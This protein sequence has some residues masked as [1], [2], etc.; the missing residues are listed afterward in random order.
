MTS[1]DIANLALNE[2]ASSNLIDSLTEQSSTA[3]TV[4]AWYEPL[5]KALLRAAPWGCARTQRMLTQV[6]DS[7]AGTSPYPWSYKFAYPSDCVHLRYLLPTVPAGPVGPQ[8]DVGAPPPQWQSPS[9][10]NRFLTHVEP[11]VGAG[12][13]NKYIISN[14]PNAIAVFNLD[15]NNPDIWD[16]LFQLAMVAALASKLAMPVTGDTAIRDRMIQTAQNAINEARAA[17]ANEAIQTSDHIPDW[18][19]GRNGYP[20]NYAPQWGTWLAPWSDMNW[21][22]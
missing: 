19:A 6:G 2:I 20:S 15:V 9:R 21:G 3:A 12:V 14:L 22:T 7:S 17:S 18:I 11:G 8:V 4:R 5:R 1:T 16:P 10:A 13:Y